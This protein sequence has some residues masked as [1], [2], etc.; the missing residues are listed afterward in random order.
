MFLLNVSSWEQTIVQVSAI[1]RAPLKTGSS[2]NFR[3]QWHFFVPQ[4]E[5]TINGIGASMK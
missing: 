4:S 3:L 1:T 2:I 5:L